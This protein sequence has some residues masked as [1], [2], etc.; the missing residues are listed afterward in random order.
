[1][2][3]KQFPIKI[4]SCWVP[5]KRDQCTNHSRT[6]NCVFNEWFES[7]QDKST[8]NQKTDPIFTVS[9]EFTDPPVFHL[10]LDLDLNPQIEI[11]ATQQQNLGLIQ[12]TVSSFVRI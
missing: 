6:Q 12:F 10:N 1:M 5:L 4:L 3:E 7:V 2:E 8:W 9:Q 11:D